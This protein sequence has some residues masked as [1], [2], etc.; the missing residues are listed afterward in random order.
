MPP[1]DTRDTSQSAFS[2]FSEVQDSNSCTCVNGCPATMKNFAACPASG[3]VLSTCA[4]LDLV[5]SSLARPTS[6]SRTSRDPVVTRPQAATANAREFSTDSC[7]TCLRCR[8]SSVVQTVIWVSSVRGSLQQENRSQV[9]PQRER[10][11]AMAEGTTVKIT[12]RAAQAIHVEHVCFTGHVNDVG[13]KLVGHQVWR[14]S[15]HSFVTNAR[16]FLDETCRLGICARIVHMDSTA[17]GSA[18]PLTNITIELSPKVNIFSSSCFACFATTGDTSLRRG[19]FRALAVRAICDLSER[20][21]LP[22]FIRGLGKKA[23]FTQQLCEKQ[24]SSSSCARSC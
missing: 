17:K 21:F 16:W 9:A 2:R 3:L 11:D 8:A 6:E 10:L 4:I 14:L 7:S 12:A 24:R 19:F 23:R 18:H 20:Q 15:L 5:W 22:C 1:L 13:E